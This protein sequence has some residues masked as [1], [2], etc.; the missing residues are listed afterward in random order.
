M[1]RITMR[2]M[3]RTRN[4]IENA[5][6]DCVNLVYLDLAYDT[7]N[8]TLYFIQSMPFLRYSDIT[9]AKM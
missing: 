2:T 4:L 6:N 1:M 5:L 7:S 8:F 9:A 3:M